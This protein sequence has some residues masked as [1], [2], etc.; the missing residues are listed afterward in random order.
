VKPWWE[1]AACAGVDPELWHPNAG[2]GD[3]HPS[4]IICRICDVRT[5]CRADI[6]RVEKGVP[7]QYRWGIWAGLDPGQRWL[8]DGGVVDPNPCGTARGYRGH[9][10]DGSDPCWQCIAANELQARKA[11]ARQE[12]KKE[13]KK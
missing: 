2:V 11:R 8:E 7:L 5:E 12:K 1:S 4:R 10:Q 13:E 6:K 3:A 9:V